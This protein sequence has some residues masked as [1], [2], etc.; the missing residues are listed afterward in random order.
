VKGHK[1]VRV[2]FGDRLASV[3]E[4]M[5][6][7][8]RALWTQGVKTVSSREEDQPAVALGAFPGVGAAQRFLRVAWRAADEDMRSRMASP[9]HQDRWQY[10]VDLVHMGDGRFEPSVVSV[11]LSVEDKDTLARLLEMVCTAPRK[12]G[13]RGLAGE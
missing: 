8:L 1:T 4:G 12:A 6:R 13:G 3:D 7:L 9:G 2:K 5:R 10:D 11:R